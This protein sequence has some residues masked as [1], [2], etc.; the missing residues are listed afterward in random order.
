MAIAFDNV[1]NNAVVSTGSSYSFNTHSISGPNSAL[2]LIFNGNGT[3]DVTTV[4][5]AGN[6]MTLLSKIRTPSDRWNYMYWYPGLTGVASVSISCSGTFSGS[7]AA[8]MSYT[9]V[10]QTGIPDAT[11]TG[12]G[13]GISDLTVSLT[14]IA[15]NC[16]LVGVGGSSFTAQSANTGT[17]MRSN[18]AN[19]VAGYDSNGAKTP[20]GSFSLSF[21]DSH[22]GGDNMAMAVASLAPASTYP[23]YIGFFNLLDSRFL[24]G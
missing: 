11:N 12:S 1:T 23:S 16:W 13:T 19:G 17:T 20:A 21:H 18:G 4:T 8:A 3:D 22:A 10:A 14:T 2:I 24:H 7:V 5:A 9:G 15:N 6:N